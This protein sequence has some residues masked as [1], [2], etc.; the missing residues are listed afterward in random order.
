MAL[1]LIDQLS[2]HFNAA[3]FKDEYAN[4]LRLV[5]EQKKK[6][7]KPSSHGKEPEFTKMKDLMSALKRSLEREKVRAH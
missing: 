6:G 4:E 7:K 3:D 5:I 1:M 2:G